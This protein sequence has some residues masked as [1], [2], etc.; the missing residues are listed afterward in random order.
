MRLSA[1]PLT[2]LKSRSL[3]Q[4][5]GRFPRNQVAFPNPDPDQSNFLHRLMLPR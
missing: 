2:Y 4:K 5:P 3:S 1:N